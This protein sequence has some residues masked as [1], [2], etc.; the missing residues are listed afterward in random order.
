MTYEQA[1]KHNDKITEQI[2]A[3]QDDYLSKFRVRVVERLEDGR[4]QT[5][6]DITTDYIKEGDTK[7]IYNDYRSMYPEQDKFFVLVQ[8]VEDV[9]RRVSVRL[10]KRT[11]S[12]REPTMRDPTP[13]EMGQ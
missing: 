6:E 10:P 9:K 5:L 1:K 12:D 11:D 7:S 13:E 3:L 4:R 8:K 2:K